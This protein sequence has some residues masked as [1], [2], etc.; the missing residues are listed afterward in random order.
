MATALVN[1]CGRDLHLY[2]VGRMHPS[3]PAATIDGLCP[4]YHARTATRR[5]W[6][7][8]ICPEFTP[9]GALPTRVLQDCVDQFVADVRGR[10]GLRLEAKAAARAV[11]AIWSERPRWTYWASTSS[12][13]ASC[14]DLVTV[15]VDD[16]NDVGVIAISR[17]PLRLSTLHAMGLSACSGDA[18]GRIVLEA[19]VRA[20]DP[21]ILASTDAEM[22]QRRAMLHRDPRP[23]RSGPYRMTVID[24]QGPIGHFGPHVGESTEAFI[25][26]YLLRGYARV[27]DIDNGRKPVTRS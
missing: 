22:S 4:G 25:A 5:N 14:A 12:A 26:S 20:G 9:G 3:A 19:A 10:E 27:A 15:P 16:G 21:V 7:Q 24:N 2:G 13:P 1:L 8:D 6:Y 17:M 11:G 18:M 23:D